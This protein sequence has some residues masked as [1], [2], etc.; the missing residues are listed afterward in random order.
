M[1]KL[2]K[3]IIG[4]TGNIASGKSLISDYLNDLGYKII[5]TDVITNELYAHNLYLKAALINLFT[6][7]IINNNQINKTMIAKIVFSDL[8]KLKQ[9]N[10]LIH[11]LIKKETIRQINDYFNNNPQSELIFVVVPL[12]YE[13][14]FN[15]I[16]NKVIFIKVDDKLQIER[17]MK[18]NNL[19]KKDALLRIKTQI[20][21]E[22][23]ISKADYVIDNNK[24]KR[25]LLAQVDI[26]LKEIEV[27]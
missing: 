3:K 23:K 4:I 26:I 19:T 15:K 20:K 14:N 7:E 22:L 27:K 13:T 6:D 1:F 12:L 10:D 25:H 17:L 8:N 24:T 9:L 2:S 21:Q 18:R 11:P 16:V 5:D